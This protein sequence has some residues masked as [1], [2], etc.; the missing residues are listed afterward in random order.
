MM[1][2]N[3]KRA[4]SANIHETCGPPM[5]RQPTSLPTAQ[6]EGHT[7]APKTDLDAAEEVLWV[8]RKINISLVAPH[9]SLTKPEAKQEPQET[10]ASKP[11]IVLH[12]KVHP[13]W[14]HLPFHNLEDIQLKIAINAHETNRDIVFFAAQSAS[15]T[16]MAPW[17][18]NMALCLDL[19]QEAVIVTKAGPD[20]LKTH[21]MLLGQDMED[22]L[23]H[24]E[25]Y[26]H[27]AVI[28]QKMSRYW[29]AEI[30]AILGE[31]SDKVLSIKNPFDKSQRDF[32]VAEPVDLEVCRMI[33]LLETIKEHFRRLSGLSIPEVHDIF[34]KRTEIKVV[35][36]AVTDGELAFEHEVHSK[37]IEQMGVPME[38]VKRMPRAE[39]CAF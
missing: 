19:P 21:E 36:C 33:H 35:S 26:Q 28:E 24:K 11:S 5:K 29:F 18:R 20:R 34:L 4:A 15:L 3:K 16:R 14:Q 8:E 25:R 39:A 12:H 6:P 22:A 27:L 10:Q 13:S 9:Q 23:K 17:K 32:K 31:E 1:T 7:P 30:K 38:N 37:W 2:R